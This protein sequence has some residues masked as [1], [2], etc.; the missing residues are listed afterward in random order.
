MGTPSAEDPLVIAFHGNADLAEWMVPWALELH[1]RTGAAVVVPEYRG[2][3]MLSGRPTYATGQADALAMLAFLHGLL[4][5]PPRRLVLF[6]HSLGSAIAA[7]LAWSAPPAAIALQSPFTSARAMASRL[8]FPTYLPIWSRLS[9][10][11]Y[12]TP[13]RVAALDCPVHV[14]H[15]MRD[16]VVPVAMGQAVFAAARQPGRLLLV[17]DAGHNDVP[18][19][20]ADRY[21]QWLVH[22]VLSDDGRRAQT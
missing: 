19:V 17:S 6:G 8:F 18:D 20:A 15:G 22:A 11:H 4:G 1:A 10:V 21:W 3:G 9:R 16:R 2:Y 12:D 13:R 14:A 5:G 7:E